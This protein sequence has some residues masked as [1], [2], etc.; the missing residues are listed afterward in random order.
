MSVLQVSELLVTDDL[1]AVA[2]EAA[3]LALV[4]LV[5]WSSQLWVVF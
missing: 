1:N 2:M 3:P 5:M 4:I